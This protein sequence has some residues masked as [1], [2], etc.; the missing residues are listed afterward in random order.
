MRKTALKNNHGM[1]TE[2][3][4]A[5]LMSII[6]GSSLLIVGVEVSMFVVSTIRQ[7]RSID[8]ATVASYAAES[9]VE[10]ALHQIRKEGRTTLRSD[11]E[12]SSPLY[13]VDARDASW[14]FKKG[15]TIDDEKFSTT[16][17]TLTKKFLGEQEAIDIHLYT[18]DESGL[19]V[20]T[21]RMENMRIS[22]KVDTCASSDEN[23]WIETTAVSWPLMG[24]L[25]QWSTTAI[26]KDF[27]QAQSGAQSV[28]VPLAA[29]VSSDQSLD[30][31]GMTLRVKPFF[32]SLREV[33]FSFPDRDNPS[34]LVPIPNYVRIAPLGTFGDIQK[35][36]EVVAT[37]K[38]GTTG[39]FDFVIF[40]E[41]AVDKKEE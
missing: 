11:T 28:I 1:R 2:R 19:T 15:D 38:Q 41:E 5:L 39:I 21:D 35:S 14:T 32:C 30:A 18:A 10:S 6:I 26:R 17:T 40:S 20:A 23:P 9:G 4:S 13:T 27:Q 7:A 29:L 36:S 37:Q 24:R 34:A 16:V 22:W 12:I 25:V 33:S 31:V 3:G 8:R